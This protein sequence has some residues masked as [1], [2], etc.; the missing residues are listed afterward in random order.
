MKRYSAFTV[1]VANDISERLYIFDDANNTSWD[2]VPYS[3]FRSKDTGDQL[4]SMLNKMSS[5]RL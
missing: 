5:G 4:S 1:M 3:A 2:I